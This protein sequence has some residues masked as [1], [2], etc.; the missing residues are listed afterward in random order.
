VYTDVVT[1]NGNGTYTTASGNNPGGY[2]PTATG[3]YLWTATYSGDSNNSG[4]SDNG[5]NESETVSPASPAVATTAGSTIVIGSG[6]KMNDSALLSGGFNPTGTIT[7][8]LHNSS[9]I[10]VYTDVVTVNGNGTYTTASGNNPGGYLPSATGLYLWSATY[11]GDSNNNGAS[12]NGEN[13]SEPVS[14][15][16]PTISTV[17]GG[18]VVVGNGKLTDTADLEGGYNPKGTIT[19]TL[20]L[21]GNVL[22]VEP[23]QV[24]GNG[25]YSTPNGFTPT[26]PGTYQWVASYSGD[27]NN[28]SVASA[29]GDEPETA[30]IPNFIVISEDAAAEQDDSSVPDQVAVINK[31]VANSVLVEFNAYD[32]SYRAGV[33]T[34]LADLDGDGIPEIITA[35]G[36]LYNQ[37]GPSHQNEVRVFKLD[38]SGDPNH[39]TVHELTQYRINAYS[40]KVD[41]GVQ[42]ALGDVNGDG[43]LDL[44]TVPTRGPSEVKVFY[45][46]SATDPQHPFQ[47][48]A[49]KRADFFAFSKNFIGGAV[50]GVA[51]MGTFCVGKTVNAKAQ[52]GYSEV[53]VG[54]GS[55]MR[56]TIEIFNFASKTPH[57]P[58]QTPSLV[59]T[60]LPF[61]STFRGGVFFD[62]GRMN[63]DAI[64]DLVIGT[65]NGGKSMVEVRNGCNGALITQ[66]QSYHD[67]SPSIP[68]PDNQQSPVRVALLDNNGDGVADQIVTIQGTDGKSRD[69]KFWKNPLTAPAIDHVLH[70]DSPSLFG[71]YLEEFIAIGGLSSTRSQRP[72]G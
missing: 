54:N 2:L 3:T 62:L 8:S 40:T 26:V 35:P 59:R 30:T 66:F 24:N 42:L 17:T 51:D 22:D 72:V 49:G 23:V 14:P 69:I 70:E 64:P 67:S 38:F 20:T 15:A 44:V 46:Q 36:R 68:K 19:F 53:I 57:V 18:S 1:V 43:L 6:L 28:K 7:F 47:D 33:R 9:N 25:H 45:N 60:I 12:D 5:E 32:P 56:S 65:G 31:D 4:A 50:L 58:L 41:G 21:N 37:E 55:G 16:S 39:P 48:V 34:A 27:V 13:E 71:D 11:S 61:S 29:L 52:D 63:N 10:V